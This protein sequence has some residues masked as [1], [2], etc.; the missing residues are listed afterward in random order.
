MQNALCWSLS[1]LLWGGLFPALHFETCPANSS[2]LKARRK[3]ALL[4]TTHV[5]SEGPCHLPLSPHGERAAG[6][7]IKARTLC[8]AA[9]HLSRRVQVRV[10]RPFGPRNLRQFAR[11]CGKSWKIEEVRCH[12]VKAEMHAVQRGPTVLMKGCAE[13]HRRSAAAPA[14]SLEPDPAC[15]M[16]NFHH[17]LVARP[18]SKDVIRGA[19]CR[20]SIDEDGLER[21]PRWS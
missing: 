1:L 17:R 8:Q 20:W 16:A 19:P 2:P 15:R 6:L 18:T 14:Q 13:G 10:R 4:V 5:W 9:Q 11:K 12:P 21:P 3:L 7:S